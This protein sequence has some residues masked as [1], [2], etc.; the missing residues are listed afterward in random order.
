MI[1][2]STTQVTP[3]QIRQRRVIS[4][5]ETATK[6]AADWQTVNNLPPKKSL[7][8]NLAVASTLVLCAVTLRTGALPSLSTATDAILTAA[9][10]HSLLDEQLGKLSFVSA[11]FPEAVL[12]FGESRTTALPLPVSGGVVVHAWSES[13]PYLSFRSSTTQVHSSADGEVT[14]IYHGYGDERLIQVTGNNGLSCL[15][16]NLEDVTV[17]LGDAVRVGSLL[18][19]LLPGEDLVL[20]VR[21]DGTNIDPASYFMQ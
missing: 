13:E 2:T 3:L 6:P 17:H 4:S 20:E 21:Q 5:A 1:E 14:G 9:T 18:G 8:K 10:D 7:L 16:G 15:Y 19:T 11:L 12:V